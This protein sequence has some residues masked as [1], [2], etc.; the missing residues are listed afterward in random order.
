M[1]RPDVTPYDRYMA[2]R[3][4]ARVAALCIFLLLIVMMFAGRILI[5]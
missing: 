4:R 5:R 3:R 2:R 1:I